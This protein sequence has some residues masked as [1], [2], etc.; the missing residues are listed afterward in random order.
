MP[1]RAGIFVSFT[2]W[3]TFEEYAWAQVECEESSG[4]AAVLAAGAD[5]MHAK[6]PLKSAEGSGLASAV[7]ARIVRDAKAALRA[8]QGRVVAGDD[9]AVDRG[10]DGG[11]GADK[12]EVLATRYLLLRLSPSLLK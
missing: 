2:W 9:A 5:H 1:A 11:E 7:A 4:T 8:A 12:D 10:W 6:I 3:L